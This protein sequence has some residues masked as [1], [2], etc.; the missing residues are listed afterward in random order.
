[1][2]QTGTS[3]ISSIGYTG[4]LTEITPVDPRIDAIPV[5]SNGRLTLYVDAFRLYT[6]RASPILTS[7]KFMA[8]VPSLK[9]AQAA[10]T[11]TPP[12]PAKQNFLSFPEPPTSS[13]NPSSNAQC[14]QVSP[15]VGPSSLVVNRQKALSEDP[16]TYELRNTFR[17]ASVRDV[18]TRKAADSLVSLLS[19]DVPSDVALGGFVLSYYDDD[20]GVTSSVAANA[21]QKKLS[22]AKHRRKRSM[23]FTEQFLMGVGRARS[24][25]AVSGRRRTQ[26]VD[27]SLPRQ[28]TTKSKRKKG[29]MRRNFADQRLRV[30]GRFI[31]KEDEI[32]LRELL[33][34]I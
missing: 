14:D 3:V 32:L 22:A 4:S 15:L 2:Q 6:L 16:V 24:S 11:T 26:S 18:R 31:K 33:K 9:L 10:V 23:S 5:G 19:A 28:K 25:S 34:M 20:G 13:K 21:K 7:S 12:A 1:M 27:A 30:K 29:E 17:S 8:S